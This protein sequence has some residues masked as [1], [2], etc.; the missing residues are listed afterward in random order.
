M[1][2][3]IRKKLES[4]LVAS[5]IALA[6][7]AARSMNEEEFMQNKPQHLRWTASHQAESK[8]MVL[9]ANM[10]A[11]CLKSGIGYAVNHKS[12]LEGCAKGSLAGA[13]AFAGEYT[14]TY[15]EHPGAGAVGKLVHDLGISMS[16]NAMHGEGMLSQYQT[17]I[18]PVTLTFSGGIVP[19]ASFTIVPAV[20]MVMNFAKGRSFDL[21]DSLSNLTP[22]FKM[23]PV[24]M[25]GVDASNGVA[26]GY[27]KGNVVSYADW[28]GV[29]NLTLSHEL[30]HSL[31]WSKLRFTNDLV[32]F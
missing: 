27:T 26:L 11:G 16:D 24:F 7:A 30:N 21:G 14:A 5:A 29:G 19:R 3:G 6:P 22:V 18:G 17:D 9:G 1:F 28:E 12:F 23:D 10:V 31:F 32:P 2:S 20:G 25:N 4:L 15:N 13:I 8:A